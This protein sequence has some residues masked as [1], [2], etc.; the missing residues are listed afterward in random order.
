MNYYTIAIDK[1][2]LLSLC[3]KHLPV[4]EMAE[5]FRCSTKTIHNRFKEW[6]IKYVSPVQFRRNRIL[7]LNKKGN[8]VNEIAEALKI[9]RAV[10]LDNFRTLDI[11]Y[12]PGKPGRRK[13][14]SMAS[15]EL[16]R[17][18]Y[19]RHQAG[20]TFGKLAAE[21]GVS[22]QSVQQRIKLHKDIF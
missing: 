20:E 22:K 2:K 16:S 12:K 6:K 10:V 21:F 15:L 17:K 4:R 7:E 9:S 19:E 8:S 3:E 1:E 5:V 11:K 13:G 14:I 18:L